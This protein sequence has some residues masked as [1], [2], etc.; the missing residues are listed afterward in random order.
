[1]TFVPVVVDLP[2]R[3]AGVFWIRSLLFVNNPAHQEHDYLSKE[4][5]SGSHYPVFVDMGC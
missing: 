2:D 3:Q 1:V 5:P 4:L